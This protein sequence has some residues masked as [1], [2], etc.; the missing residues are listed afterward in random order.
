LGC[1]KDVSIWAG[2]RTSGIGLAEGREVIGLAE[3]RQVIEWVCVCQVLDF[4]WDNRYWLAV[5][6]QVLASRRTP[7]IGLAEEG[8]KVSAA[9]RM[10]GC[11]LA[12]E[13]RKVS[14]ARKD[15]RFWAGRWTSVFGWQKDAKELG[16][17]KNAMYLAA[18]CTPGIGLSVGHQVLIG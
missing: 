4:Q 10:L 15:V 18:M 12:E 17:Q 9:G 1:Q 5:G 3:E 11:G 8:R 16:W 14:A 2:R 7:D 13:G 6:H